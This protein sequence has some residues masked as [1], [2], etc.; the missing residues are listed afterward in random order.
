[1]RCWSTGCEAEAT[2][3]D[4]ETPAIFVNPEDHDGPKVRPAHC[5]KHHA[6]LMRRRDDNEAS[7]NRMMGGN[8]AR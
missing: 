7:W 5:A 2:H 4:L 1:M 8:R 6:E 3:P